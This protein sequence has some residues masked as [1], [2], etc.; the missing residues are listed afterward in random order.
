MRGT[1]LSRDDREDQKKIS[2]VTAL[3]ALL[4]G[5]VD[6]AG[7]FPPAELD[8]AAAVRNYTAYRASDDAWMLGRFV[9][10]V[11]RLD[12][13]AAELRAIG[14]P[15]APDWRLTALV[16]Q[17]VEGDVARA[18]AFN[19]AHAVPAMIDGLEARVSSVERL[20]HVAGAAGDFELYAE[21]PI[22]ADPG[23]LVA[24]LAAHG[25]KAKVRTGGVTADAFPTAP[26]VIRFIRACEAACVPFKAT[27][28]LHHPLTAEFP[29]TYDPASATHRMFGFLNVFLAAAFVAGGM[30]DADACRLMD[31]SDAAAFGVAGEEIRWR[32]WALTTD[33]LRAARERVAASFGSCSFREPVDGLQALL[34]AV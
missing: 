20:E 22:G 10:P 3:K 31:E 34:F 7:L 33:Q 29:L 13:L 16:G 1:E 27:A 21:V 26:D 8:M 18:R 28:G 4:A 24:A 6:Y 30:P 11:A 2:A 14:E 15:S 9:V 5:I 12:E 25:V 17:D 19:A 23:P 32:D